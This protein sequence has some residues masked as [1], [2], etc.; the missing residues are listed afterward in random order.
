MDTIQQTKPRTSPKDLF[1]NLGAIVA[2]YTV[3]IS[4]LNL[5]FSVI[6]AAYPQITY[7]YYYFGSQSIS[8][9]VSILVIFF[10]LYVFLMWFLEKD[11]ATEPDRKI[12]GLRK[13]L[14]Y[15]TLFVAGIAMAGDLV[16]ILY[17]FIDGQELNTGFVLKVLA[18]LVVTFAVFFYYI[19]DL[20][21]KLN[22]MSQ[23]VWLGIA[24]VLVI[25]SIV[26]GFAVLGSPR[27]QKLYKYDSAKIS[28]LQNIDS[29]VTYFYQVKGVLPASFSDLTT[30]GNYFT[31]PVDQQSGKSYEYQKKNAT[32]YN[33]CADFN[34]ASND[35]K[36]ASVA[37]PYPYGGATWTHPVGKY[38]FERTIDPRAYSTPKP[39][40]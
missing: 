21:G 10:P 37:A 18:V 22:P 29:Q 3:V 39:V 7:G 26:W 13:W 19:S 23:K 34:Y 2:L 5:L 16:T 30:S 28:D 8:W 33:L 32:T 4:L 27:T 38:C 36:N 15:I 17:Y 6:N 35:A 11:Y 25:G 24:A 20:R 40:Y 14:T 31:P 12:F 1:L 9:P